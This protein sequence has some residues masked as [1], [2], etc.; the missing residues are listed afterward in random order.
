MSDYYQVLQRAI[1]TLDVNDEDAR[2]QVYERARRA[3]TNQLGSFDPPLSEPERRK[4][5]S[6][7]EWAIE[8]L[9]S[10]YADAE[11]RE[12][13]HRSRRPLLASVAAGLLAAVVVAAVAVYTSLP[14]RQVASVA[15]PPPAAQAATQVSY[16]F[17]RQ[18]VY[19]RTTHPAGTII[20]QKSQKFLYVIQ[21]NV[22][23]LRYGI[24]IGD[25]CADLLGLFRIVQKQEMDADEVLAASRQ[26]QL[27]AADSFAFRV[28]N[29]SDSAGRIH[30]A[31]RADSIGRLL[32]TGCIQL[33]STDLGD[34]Y[35]RAPLG[36]RVVVMN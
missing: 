27:S 29:L 26:F 35:D 5:T 31:A 32:A 13:T 7:L 8:H 30:A 15:R 16:V 23:A 1:A 14:S 17:R 10:E 28:L 2:G 36:T 9:E 20:I 24:G 3:L 4:T 18:P 25:A 19:Y 21:P 11:S 12:R 33:V 6:A 34:L 22:V